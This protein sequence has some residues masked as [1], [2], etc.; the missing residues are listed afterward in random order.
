M[1]TRGHRPRRGA[2]VVIA[3]L[4]FLVAPVLAA[5]ARGAIDAN[6]GVAAAVF[7][8]DL[9]VFYTGQD[10]GLWQMSFLP[11]AGWRPAAEIPGTSGALTSAPAVDVYRSGAELDVFYR[12]TADAVAQRYYRAATGWSGLINLGGK[13]LAAPAVTVW[14]NQVHVFGV[15]TNKEL[16]Q[17]YFSG[18]WSGWGSL[19]GG[20][21]SAPSANVF[22]SGPQLDV[23]AR[24]TDNGLWQREYL[25]SSGWSAWHEIPGT[26][27]EMASAPSS[28]A[29][30]ATQL[31]VFYAGA[32]GGLMDVRYV[33]GSGWAPPVQIPGT[34]GTV[35]TAPAAVTFGGAIDVFY[36]STNT[37]LLQVSSSNDQTWQ[38]PV[39]P[40][41]PAP[42]APAPT[43]TVTTPTPAPVTTQTIKPSKVHHGSRPRVKAEVMITW[44]WTPRGTWIKNVKTSQFPPK[45]RVTVA[46]SGPVCP[47]TVSAGKHD[48]GLLWRRLERHRFRRGD[49]VMVK[50]TEP[51]H[52]P[53]R[54][55]FRIRHEK[56]PILKQQ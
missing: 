35:G 9:D 39:A 2:L 15:G 21:T 11:G 32:N 54:A 26:N 12:N 18:S 23:F 37:G 31:D 55:E 1:S 36:L 27:G 46:C 48:L 34:A 13:V 19:G 3:L 45:G 24:G 10:A 49:M 16:Y 20:L 52:S 25:T 51:G 17:D 56:I 33:V 30:S 29:V 41:P 22:A 4:A 8:G 5:P 14:S 7:S 43:V 47:L 6:G 38:G 28:V 44:R 42:A 53:E 50:I 40:A